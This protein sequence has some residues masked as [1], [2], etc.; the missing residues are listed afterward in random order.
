MNLWN[1]LVARWRD[2]VAAR[3]GKAWHELSYWKQRQRSEG[4]LGNAHYERLFTEMFG[5]DRSFYDGKRLLDIGCGP[6][7]SLEWATNAAQRVGL[8]PLVGAYRALGI[9]SHTMDY[10]EAPAEEIPFPDGHFDVITS[11]NSLDHVDDPAA[12]M[13][14]IARVLRPGGD[15]LLEV[16]VGHDPTPTEP[17]AFWFDVLDDLGRYFDVIDERRFEL[18]EGHWVHDAWSRGAPFD[19]GRG[20]HPGVLVARL[21]KR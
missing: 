5:V 13:A 2:V 6:R 7:G 12:V 21:R 4:T 15:F 16:E 8:D 10:C 14:E 18:P 11:I 17:I 19:L 3:R 9:G 1:A 20:R